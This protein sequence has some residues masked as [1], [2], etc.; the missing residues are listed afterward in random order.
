MNPQRPSETPAPWRQACPVAGVLPTATFLVTSAH[1]TGKEPPEK[2][3]P[4]GG[5]PEISSRIPGERGPDLA[6]TVC[7]RNLTTEYLGLQTPQLSNQVYV[8]VGDKG[9]IVVWLGLLARKELWRR[10]S[11]CGPAYEVAMNPAGLQRL[12]RG[13]PVVHGRW[14]ARLRRGR[15]TVLQALALGNVHSV[16]AVVGSSAISHTNAV[17][18]SF[19]WSSFSLRQKAAPNSAPSFMP[20]AKP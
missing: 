2:E 20:E 11:G 9:A 1:T 16:P 13:D 18:L 12:R 3:D 6:C 15:A 17:N 5:R 10:R 19:C 14:N 4:L 8:D 7:S